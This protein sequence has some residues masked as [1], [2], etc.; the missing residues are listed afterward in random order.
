[1]D[2]PIVAGGLI[3]AALYLAAI[4]FAGVIGGDHLAVAAAIGALGLTT[5]S[6]AFQMED[7]WR[8]AAVAAGASWALGIGAGI[9]LLVGYFG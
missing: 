9:D 5:V 6:Y 2:D 8:L 1:M 4:V 7:R 3:N